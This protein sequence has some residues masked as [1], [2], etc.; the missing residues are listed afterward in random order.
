ME[1]AGRMKCR[2]SWIKGEEL[3]VESRY[4][5]SCINL[6]VANENGGIVMLKK[7]PYDMLQLIYFV[8]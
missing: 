3:E 7:L 4:P 8:K 6:P 5:D 2:Q 1:T